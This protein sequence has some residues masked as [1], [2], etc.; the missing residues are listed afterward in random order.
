MIVEDVGLPGVKLFSPRI[1]KDLRGRFFETWRRSSYEEA[2]V[3]GDFV[4]DNISV[5]VRDTI[6][7]LHFQ[8]PLAQGKLVS[9]PFGRI[10]DVAVDV[11]R[12]SPN[13]GRWVGVELSDENG[14]QLW[15]PP[16]FA[17]GFAV[18]SDSAMLLYKCTKYYAPEHEHV[19]RWDDPTLC[20]TWPVSDPQLSPK[21]AA[22]KLLSEM[23]QA[24]LPSGE[25]AHG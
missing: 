7:G 22:G 17:H 2:G 3:P 25:L 10:Y 12:D 13:F 1:F 19:I 5:S 14:R 9:A 21:D 8:F 24:H 11:R 4:Q 6:R 23:D 16:G 20:I 18:M 15:V